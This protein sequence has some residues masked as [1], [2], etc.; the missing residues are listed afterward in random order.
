MMYERNKILI[1]SILL[2]MALVISVS[3]IYIIIESKNSYGDSIKISNLDKYTKGRPKNK[4]S[5]D[6]I[7]YSLLN[8]VNNNLKEDVIGKSIQDALVRDKSFSQSFND[9]TKVHEVKF[10]VDIKS[11]NQSY[12]I[13]YQWSETDNNTNLDEYGTLVKCLKKDKLIY[14]DFKCKDSISEISGIPDPIFEFLPYSTPNYRITY[15]LDYR[16]I[17]IEILTSAADERE[18]PEA[19]IAS[20]QQEAKEW[21]RSKGLDPNNYN[22]GYSVTRASLH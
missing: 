21:I 1:N 7:E 14:G 15:N 11:L 4:K 9:N 6:F 16:S 10:I 2:I 12:D 20:Y 17:D 13:S 3:A 22:I 18:N 5:L 8:T 19:A